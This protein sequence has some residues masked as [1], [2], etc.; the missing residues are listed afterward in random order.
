[1]KPSVVDTTYGDALEFSEDTQ[2]TNNALFLSNICMMLLYILILF[3]L[4]TTKYMT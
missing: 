4:P 1:M 2:R 3:L